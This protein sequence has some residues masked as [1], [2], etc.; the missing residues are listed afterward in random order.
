MIKVEIFI[1]CSL[2]IKAKQILFKNMANKF[3]VNGF[4]VTVRG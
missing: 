1:L 3:M 4:M 2:N